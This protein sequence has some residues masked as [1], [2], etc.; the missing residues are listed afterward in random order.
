MTWKG[1]SLIH[2]PGFMDKK[3][4]AGE[5]KQLVQKYSASPWQN[6][7]GNPCLH[8]QAL[9]SLTKRLQ[10]NSFACC[11]SQPLLGI[12]GEIE[13]APVLKSSWPGFEL[14]FAG[15]LPCDKMHLL[16]QSFLKRIIKQSLLARQSRFSLQSPIYLHSLLNLTGQVLYPHWDL[17]LV[18]EAKC[19][20]SGHSKN[21]SDT[22]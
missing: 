7:G 9:Y 2:T 19:S 22:L 10:S 13:R 1:A 14:W 17:V 16:L 20:R 5:R 3:T 15:H 6:E 11:V 21:F 8:P 12:V 18:K 4:E